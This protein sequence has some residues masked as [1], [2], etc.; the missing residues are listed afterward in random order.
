MRKKKKED[1]AIIVEACVS[2]PFFIFAIIMF[3][4]LIDICVTQ[5]KIGT[6]LNLAAKEISQYSYLYILTG[7]NDMQSTIYNASEGSRTT[8]D[9]T[10]DGLDS[11]SETLLDAKEGLGEDEIDMDALIADV[12][13]VGADAG[14]IYDKWSAELADPKKFIKSFVA[15]AGNEAM[16]GAKSVLIGEVVGKAFMVKNLQTGSEGESGNNAAAEKFLR[17]NHVEPKGTSY[18]AGLDFDKTKIFANGQ[19]ERIQLVVTYKIHVVKLLNIDFNFTIQQCA[20]TKAWGNG[21]DGG[22]KE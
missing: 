18:L 3:L 22:K 19:T 9:V 7:A 17:L 4:S 10:L 5:A 14:K 21:I 15:L 13:S 6:A 16:E 1:G 11:M 20:L 12:K 8:I 2:F